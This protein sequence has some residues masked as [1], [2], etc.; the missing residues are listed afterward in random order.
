M[1]HYVKQ[2]TLQVHKGLSD[3]LNDEILPGLSL[4]SNQIWQGFAELVNK[5][6]PINRELLAQRDH[7]QTQIN[8]WH[9]ANPRQ[10]VED[11]ARY[12]HFLE[13]IGYLVPEGEHFAA[14]TQNVDDEIAH[15]A[16]PQLVVPVNNARFALN[17]ANARWGSLYDAYY[18]TDVIAEENDSGKVAATGGYNPRRGQAVIQKATEFLDQALPLAK[19]LHAQVIDY[20]LGA[21]Q[22]FIELDDGSMTN[23]A[24]PK[25]FVAY[26]Q[27]AEAL[28]L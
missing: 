2:S 5:L 9:Q 4:E 7:L 3:L 20:R 16:G 25:E 6:L 10:C 1:T 19:G 15:I 12:K 28:V 13:D 14:G 11:F 22:L 23:L 18:G 8:H 27:D 26:N 21:G 17:A 24:Q